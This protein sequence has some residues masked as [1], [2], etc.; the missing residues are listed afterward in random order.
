M[1]PSALFCIFFP[2]SVCLPFLPPLL[3][4]SSSAAAAAAG[5][6][7]AVGAPVL[8]AWVDAAAARVGTA[9]LVG[10]R[11]ADDFRVGGVASPVPQAASPL[12]RLRLHRPVLRAAE[13]AALSDWLLDVVEQQPAVQL[14]RVDLPASDA[15]LCLALWSRLHGRGGFWVVC[16]DQAVSNLFPVLHCTFVFYSLI[17]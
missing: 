14:W 10:V 5:S 7:A 4:M 17:L 12:V 1:L 11:P 9:G 13:P 3:A 15:K 16:N 2:L 6:A 8:G